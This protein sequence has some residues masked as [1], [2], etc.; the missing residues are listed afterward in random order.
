MEAAPDPGRARA[1]YQSRTTAYNA[2]PR[3]ERGRARPG[4]PIRAI[5]FP[6][7]RAHIDLQGMSSKRSDDTETFPAAYRLLEQLTGSWKTQAIYVAAKLRIADLLADGPRPGS[8]LADTA[9]VPE[10]SLRRLLRAL[11]TL[12]ICV[13]EGDGVFAITPMGALL[14]ADAPESLRSWTLWWGDQLWRLWGSLDYSVATGESA[15]KRLLGTE[16]FEHLEGDAEA[17][18]TFNQA[19]IELT[20]LAAGGVIRA[21]D[22]SGL[23][24]IAD[25]G[26]GYGELLS[27]VLQ[28]HPQA[29]G[30]L[31]DRPH[32][33]ECARERF[34]AA[35]LASR[36]EFRAGDF[37]DAVPAG[38]DAY[39][40]K[41]V[42]HDW[43]DENSRRILENC[44]RALGEQ[45]RLLVIEQVVPDRLDT[46]A[47]H[48][49]LVRS[50]LTMLVAHGAQERTEAE[51]RRL[52]DSAGLKLV[53]IRPTDSTLSVIEA[54]AR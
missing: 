20:R 1:A 39:L 29:A 40:L 4:P 52:L 15:R 27:A 10:A 18:A 48:Q 41:N 8:E 36:C 11:T 50:D 14:A 33:V 16:G 53:A 6:P 2:M 22:F 21:F 42:I 24:L 49:S 47:R 38:A 31:F 44:G 5:D 19:M 7:A 45:S 23:K 54:V 46:S 43:N 13:E 28:A 26:G 32:A 12:G 34:S 30:L 3:T 17:A 37:F 25:V 51:F 35:G 9:G